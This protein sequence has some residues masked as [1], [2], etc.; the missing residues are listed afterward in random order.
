M[1]DFS[2]LQITLVALAVL[3]EFAWKGAALWRAANLG[4]REWFVILLVI[5]TVGILP[6]VYLLTNPKKA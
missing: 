3:W 6:I 2:T 4:Q 1:N 5:N